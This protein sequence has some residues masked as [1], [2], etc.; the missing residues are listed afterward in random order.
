MNLFKESLRSLGLDEFLPLPFCLC[1]M[2]ERGARVENVLKI[3][4]IDPLKISLDV[5][6]GTVSLTGE[7]LYVISYDSGDVTI[8]GKIKG[9]VIAE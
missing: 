2:G 6:N 8:G 9:V 4:E 7:D 3:S 1:V 5:K